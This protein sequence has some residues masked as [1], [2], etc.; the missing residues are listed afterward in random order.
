MVSHNYHGD[1]FGMYG[2]IESLRYVK[3][4]NIVL[5]VDQDTTKTN[6]QTKR[7]DLWLWGG[8][9]ELKKDSQKVQTSS[10]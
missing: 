8:D 6:S 7:S 1:H 2:N 9:A 10:L 4:T 3:G 5:Y